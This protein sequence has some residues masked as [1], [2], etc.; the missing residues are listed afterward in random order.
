MKEKVTIPLRADDA[1][2]RQIKNID[3]SLRSVRASTRALTAPLRALG[4]TYAGIKAS[5]LS[6]HTAFTGIVGFLAAR[7]Y[8][9]VIDQADALGKLASAT[10]DTV[11]ALSELSVA[12]GY[13]GVSDD[14][15]RPLLTQ[16]QNLQTQAARGVPDTVRA[17]EQLGLT[18]GAVP[19]ETIA[20]LADAVDR[21]GLEDARTY[22]T[23]L[24]PDK[25]LAV[26]QLVGSG[27]EGY[28]ASL[29]RARDAGGVITPE[30]AAAAR[31]FN[32]ALVDI[33]TQVEGLFR[34][35]VLNTGPSIV[36]VLEAARDTLRETGPIASRLAEGLGLLVGAFNSKA[37]GVRNDV[38]INSEIIAATRKHQE[39]STELDLVVELLTE[40]AEVRD[41]STRLFLEDQIADSRA[42][43]EQLE[44][45]I[46]EAVRHV[47]ALRRERDELRNP[48]AAASP[49]R[50]APSTSD[51]DASLAAAADGIPDSVR[52]AILRLKQPLRDVRVQ[53]HQLEAA[54]ELL[55]LDKT[56]AASKVDVGEHAN[57]VY[58]ANIEL[59]RQAAEVEGG[60]AVGFER[61]ARAA[62][63]QIGSLSEHGAALFDT[64]AT[65][66]TALGDALLIDFS[67][68]AQDLADRIREALRNELQ[69]Y[70]S[71]AF[72]N[73]ISIFFGSL[74]APGFSSV[75]GLAGFEAWGFMPNSVNAEGN[76]YDRGELQPFALG[77]VV[78]GDREHVLP[79]ERL[80]GVLGVDG[81]AEGRT[82]QLDVHCSD[83]A[84]WLQENEHELRRHFHRF[85]R[86]EGLPASTLSEQVRR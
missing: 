63:E 60:F 57:I 59:A 51:A 18:I 15:L 76:V 46:A 3:R 8:K 26:L 74:T 4:A 19:S 64:M 81:G 84:K 37:L 42:Y 69:K 27:V 58:L 77:G 21:L 38:E 75:G 31:E 80:G 41:E 85:R 50:S 24:F 62:G 72:K 45:Q 32:V 86:G 82:Y 78:G 7:G 36:G 71:Y 28:R 53:L 49:R 65:E 54:E 2:S 52:K 25:A 70:S 30:M 73:A 47:E 5:V 12:F 39:L 44:A 16:L 43:A 22:I 33:S 14:N 20:E 10:G 35:F 55:R 61:A 6:V 1:A 13:A 17:F 40:T 56:L 67:E 79:L 29:Q 34:T 83:G 48:Q 66:L 23:K 68:A 11:E 9:S